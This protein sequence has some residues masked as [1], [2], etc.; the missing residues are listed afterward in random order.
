MLSVQKP[1]FL[2]GCEKQTLVWP[3]RKLTLSAEQT[4]MCSAANGWFPPDL[5]VS[6]RV[7]PP[8]WARPFDT[9]RVKDSKSQYVWIERPKLDK[10]ANSGYRKQVANGCIGVA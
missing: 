3:Q 7:G 6:T 5:H 10:F 1:P 4:S 8:G 2:E 9:T